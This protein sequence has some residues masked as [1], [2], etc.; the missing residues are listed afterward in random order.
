M[1]VCF[2]TVGLNAAHSFCHL[3][4]D[5]APPEASSA[6]EVYFVLTRSD[7]IPSQPVLTQEE[8]GLHLVLL[9]L[10]TLHAN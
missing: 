3:A 7:L 5:K 9:F 6:H 2:T 10:L 8:C 1:R 4:S